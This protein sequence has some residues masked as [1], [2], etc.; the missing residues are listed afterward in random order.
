MFG[1]IVFVLVVMLLLLAALD[2][3]VGV[4]NDAA[5][6]LNSSVGTKIAPLYVV[7]I[8]A[9]VGVLTGATFS[10]GMMEIAR[11]GMLHPDMFAFEEIILIFVAVM[12]S[13]VLLLNTFNSLGLPTSTTVSIIFEILE[14]QKEIVT[15]V[16][17]DHESFWFVIPDK[18][19]ESKDIFIPWN[20]I[21]DAD[22]WDKV[23]VRIVKKW[24]KNPQWIITKILE[25]NLSTTD[26]EI[27]DF[28]EDDK[29]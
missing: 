13:D 10:S 16:F 11:K 25:E 8:V 22:D 15:W 9:S 14:S 28:D 7:L 5:N 21:N 19:F 12:I 24:P 23:E 6:F 2:L 4:S 17:K 29:F 3:F 26:F 27:I 18:E 1:T 20:D